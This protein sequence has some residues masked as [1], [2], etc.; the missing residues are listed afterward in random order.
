MDILQIVPRLP[1]HTD[2]VG[3]YAL[4]LGAQLWD[5]HGIY[6][7]FL[8]VLFELDYSPLEHGFPIAR[9]SAHTSEALMA[10]YPTS[11]KAV[12]LHYSNYPYFKGQLDAPFWLSAALRCLLQAHNIPLVV[13]FHELP[14]LDLKILKVFNPWQS[15]VSQ[16]L[17]QLAS[18]VVTDS[19]RFKKVLSRWSSHSIPC[20]P[21][22]SNIGEPDRVPPLGDRR[23]QL[24]I[25]GGHDRSRIYRNHLPALLRACQILKIEQIIDIGRPLDL[26]PQ[27]FGDLQWV[28]MGFQP[29]EVVSQTLLKSFAGMI[30]YTRFPGDLG[31]SSVFAAFTA[32]GVLPL[33]TAYNPSEKDGLHLHQQYLTPTTLQSTTA[34]NHLQAIAT[35]A[36]HWY[37]QHTLAKNAAIFA[38]QLLQTPQRH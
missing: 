24:V 21:D 10:A 27:Q 15:R 18:G 13:M 22:F 11:A 35:A 6:S 20:I 23:R 36:H 19:Y 26:D 17:A 4:R 9:L 5:D 28:Q 14:T 37:Q 8:P 31:K 2:G 33:V 30:D 38:E 3:D 29:S 34:L 32:H 16:Q 25:F 12:L 1:P 7:H